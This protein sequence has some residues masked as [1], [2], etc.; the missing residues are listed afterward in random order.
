M[1]EATAAAIDAAVEEM[2][3]TATD[4]DNETF[5][6]QTVSLLILNEGRLNKYQATLEL[7]FRV[8]EAV[9]FARSHDRGR[10]D[11]LN[12]LLAL[13]PAAN[14]KLAALSGRAPD[15]EGRLPFDVVFWVAEIAE[16]L[17][18]EPRTDEALGGGANG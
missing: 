4:W 6:T 16:Q 1:A 7:V 10:R 17:G 13:N 2:A 18:I 12:A 3:T 15:P 9:V 5:A 8:H 11:M 14:A